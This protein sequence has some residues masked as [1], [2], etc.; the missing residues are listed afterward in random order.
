[1][2]GGLIKPVQLADGLWR[3][4]CYHMAIYLLRGP[5]G[6]ALVEAGVSVTAPLVLAQ[7]DSLEVNRD[8]VRIIAITHGHADHIGGLPGLIAG[9]PWAVVTASKEALKPFSKSSTVERLAG[10]DAWTSAEI[11]SRDKVASEGAVP[12]TDA[13]PLGGIKLIKAGDEI[14]L[15]GVAVRVFSGGGHAPGGLL[16]WVPEFGAALCADSAGFVTAGGPAF[17]MFF[18]SYRKYQQ[19]LAALDELG[20]DILCPGHQQW[21]Q[22]RDARWFLRT[23]SIR[24]A[25]DA[26]NI[27]KRYK[28]GAT[29]KELAQWLFDRYYH[30]ELTIYTPSNIYYCCQLIVTRS[31]E[32]QSAVA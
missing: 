21:W 27:R 8:E 20:P 16:Y 13:F 10:E 28:D 32:D 22:G 12:L 15:A 25:E 17:P 3:L 23:S 19:E 2:G 14:E 6:A 31:L 30:G 7:L 26:M 11:M 24:L 5:A 1:M 18:V 9:L 4:G 29:P